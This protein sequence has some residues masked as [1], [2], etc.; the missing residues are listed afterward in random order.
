ME[1][2]DASERRAFQLSV[3]RTAY[4][5][6]RSY[7]HLDE[8]PLSADVPSGE[9][10]SADY[11]LI[12]ARVLGRLSDNFLAALRVILERR[13]GEDSSEPDIE[14]IAKAFDSLKQLSWCDL[15]QDYDVLKRFVEDISTHLP[16]TLSQAS[17]FAFDLEKTMFG[18][19]SALRDALIEG[20]TGF[21][22][23]TLFAMLGLAQTG[24]RDSLAAT[25][26]RDFEALSF[27]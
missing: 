2:G 19:E 3:A 14:A 17:R 24:G 6:V 10:F 5:F 23:T 9:A 26:T 21:L 18:L 4:D 12:P 20:P 27:S 1:L 16:S 13:L 11:G 7:P 15:L 8:V 25:S 22:K